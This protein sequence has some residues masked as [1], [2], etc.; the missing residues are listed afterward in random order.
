M[1]F[2]LNLIIMDQPKGNSKD[3]GHMVKVNNKEAIKIGDSLTK[4]SNKTKDKGNKI[5]VSHNRVKVNKVSGLNK[6]KGKGKSHQI[7]LQTREDRTVV[8]A[9]FYE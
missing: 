6:I 7:S 9:L 3:N 2:W 4:V 8:P 5:G 1:K